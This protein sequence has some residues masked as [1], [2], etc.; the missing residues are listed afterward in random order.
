MPS[1]IYVRT[2]FHKQRLKAVHKRGEEVYNWKGGKNRFPNCN[3]CNKPLSRNDAKLC[4]KCFS[5]IAGGWNKGRKLSEATKQKMRE[6]HLGKKHSD[7]HKSKIGEASKR[8][9]QTEEYKKKM[10]FKK[11]FTPWNKDKICPQMQGEHCHMYKGGISR[12]YKTGYNS[13]QYRQWRRDVFVRDE[14]IC[15]ECGI[16][17]TYITAHHVKPFAFYP[18]LRFDISNGITLC[19]D[20]HS[21]MDNY[22]AR[23]KR[24]KNV[25][26][27]C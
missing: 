12:V 1:G 5:K 13:P 10:K 27:L 25:K 6:K 11:G 21:K 9:W 8:L 18:D 7:E 26:I 15:Q 24:R 4:K 2:E 19:E 23:F 16:K 22:R 17:H 3:I 14:F 20:C